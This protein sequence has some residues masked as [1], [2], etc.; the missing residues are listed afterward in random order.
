MGYVWLIRCYLITPL[1]LL[2]ACQWGT[3]LFPPDPDGLSTDYITTFLPACLLNP[4]AWKAFSE[5]SLVF[6]IS[7]ALSTTLD[8]R[9]FLHRSRVTFTDFHCLVLS[10][11]HLISSSRQPNVER[12]QEQQDTIKYNNTKKAEWRKH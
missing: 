4:E 7:R 6:F 3:S 1:S 11:G 12:N 8:W 5:Q 10:R 9:S 2:L